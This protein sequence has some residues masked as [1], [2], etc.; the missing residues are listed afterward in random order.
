[1][2]PYNCITC[3]RKFR[4]KISLRTHKCT[5]FAVKCESEQMTTMA[6]TVNNDMTFVTN[7]Q[8]TKPCT[9]QT[10]DE[11][12]TESCNRLGIVDH[13]ESN[14]AAA[15]TT[16]TVVSSMVYTCENTEN[17]CNTNQSTAYDCDSFNLHDLPFCV[18]DDDGETT[19]TDL[20]N[21]T[22]SMSEILPQTMDILN[23]LYENVES[24]TDN[25]RHFFQ[26]QSSHQ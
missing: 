2:M 18:V 14:H 19:N 20:A 8:E 26:S 6:T 25:Q 9:E 23:A 13:N 7:D 17:G 21:V 1:M 5:G 4:Y 3:D 15:P 24:N 11:F 22:P 16:A 10:L 12:I